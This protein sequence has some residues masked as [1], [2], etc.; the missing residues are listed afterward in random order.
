MHSVGPN[1]DDCESVHSRINSISSL[2]TLDSVNFDKHPV[3]NNN[4]NIYDNNSQDSAIFMDFNSRSES[5]GFFDESEFQNEFINTSSPSKTPS[6]CKLKNSPS[7]KERQPRATNIS[8]SMSLRRYIKWKRS[9]SCYSLPKMTLNQPR[10][11][12]SQSYSALLKDNPEEFLTVDSKAK[13]SRASRRSQLQTHYS[14]RRN[15]LV[16]SLYD[17]TFTPSF[18]RTIKINDNSNDD[19]VFEDNDIKHKRSL[20]CGLLS[21]QTKRSKLSSASNLLEYAEGFSTIDKITADSNTD[22]LR[23]KYTRQEDRPFRMVL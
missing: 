13:I 8:V 15:S 11:V 21:M 19:D 16:A 1:D 4:N 2:M 6:S 7:T 9:K 3:V 18:K 23:E 5:P 22:S 20:S 17:M 10:F 14:P 12:K